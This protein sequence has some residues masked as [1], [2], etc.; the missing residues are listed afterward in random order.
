MDLFRFVELIVLGLASVTIS[1]LLSPPVQY[2][3]PLKS[4]WHYFQALHSP[5]DPKSEETSRDD[6]K[7]PPA[8]Q[9]GNYDFTPPMSSEIGAQNYLL[10]SGFSSSVWSRVAV[11]GGHGVIGLTL[12]APSL[13]L[14]KAISHCLDLPFYTW[15]GEKDQAVWET[16][17][18]LYFLV[19]CTNILGTL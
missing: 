6:E 9:C 7:D 16:G 15:V 13:A 5:T 14:T 10:L 2:S 17:M 19:T 8:G 1:E 4:D 11:Q 12:C 18:V 3:P